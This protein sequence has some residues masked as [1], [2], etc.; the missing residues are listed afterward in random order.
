MGED[1]TDNLQER[2]DELA[3]RYAAEDGGTG[4]SYYD[5]DNYG[6]NYQDSN[7]LTDIDY[8]Q[9]NDESSPFTGGYTGE[10]DYDPVNREDDEESGEQDEDDDDDEQ[11]GVVGPDDDD[12][13]DEEDEE[14]AED[15][16]DDEDADEEDNE[17]GSGEDEEGEGGEDAS[18]G[19]NQGEDGK[20]KKKQKKP[21]RDP[22]K[23]V[24]NWRP[25]KK[26]TIKLLSET[27]G[28]CLKIS[29]IRPF[30]D[31]ASKAVKEVINSTGPNLML[32]L[33]DYI[34]KTAN[35][36]IDTIGCL[37]KLMTSHGKRLTYLALSVGEA[38]FD[39]QWLQVTLLAGLPAA[40]EVAL[41]HPVVNK[42]I[43][44][45]FAVAVPIINM[46]YSKDK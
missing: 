13:A 39:Q 27:W 41:L 15:E 14:N 2:E 46:K 8:Q 28:E 45:I 19:E 33:N 32:R 4:L 5:D 26:I 10:D 1:S 16:N 21:K 35:D 30:M 44:A 23:G 36:E 43:T 22:Y 29:Q 25:G 40:F 38:I 24:I 17:A 18:A 37:L 31:A 12:D 9:P 20:K 42:I 7:P 6:Y 3:E 11:G 34:E